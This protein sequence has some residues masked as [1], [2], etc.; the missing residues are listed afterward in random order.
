MRQQ[1]GVGMTSARARQRLIKRLRDEGISD[2]VVLATILETPRHLFL[3][4]ALRHRAYENTA[5]SIGYQQTIS[6]P[7]IVAL[8][9]QLAGV[10]EDRVKRVLDI[11][12]GCG[13]QAA[14]LSQLA[15]WVFTVERIEALSFSARE[16]LQS[17]GYKNI[18]YLCGDGYAG[19]LKKA[20]FDAIVVAAAPP[21][22]PPALMEQLAIGGRLVIPVGDDE[23][24]ALRLIERI[25]GGYTEEIVA[26][27]KFVPLVGSS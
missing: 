27:V 6:Q 13:Y 15:D 23:Q 1:A 21:V 20:P 5:L 26:A 25:P 24:Q 19:W 16:R 8:M 11:G 9:T 22:V 7:Y 17:L 18:S 14:V 12:T 10:G 3:D 4:E 2:D